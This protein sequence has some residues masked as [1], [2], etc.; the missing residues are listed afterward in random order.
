M[1]IISLNNTQLLLIERDLNGLEILMPMQIFTIA[2]KIDDQIRFP[3]LETEEKYKVICKIIKKIDRA[4]Y[5]VLPNEYYDL[6]NIENKGIENKEAEVIKQRL[7]DVLS[8][9]IDI[10]VL[11]EHDETKFIEI[12]VKEITQAMMKGNYL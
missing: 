5:N 8:K 9:Y 1:G 7:V 12:V 3:K 10:P 11:T 2:G 6:I 4:M